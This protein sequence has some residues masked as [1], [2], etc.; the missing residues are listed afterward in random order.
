MRHV[1]NVVRLHL[2]KPEVTFLVPLFILFLVLVISAIISLTLQRVGLDPSNPDFAEGARMNGG[3]TWS[4]PG[5]LVYLGVQAV[6]TTF[7]FALALGS[8][9]RAYVAGTAVANV[10]LA[11]YV[12]VVMMILLAIE[13]A[14]GHWFANIYVLDTFSLGSGNFLQ[15]GLTAFLG[16]FTALSVGGLFGAIWVRFGARGPVVLGIALGLV[17]ALIL[18]LTAPSL[19]TLIP[20]ITG[21][22]VALTVAVL[23][24]AAI[25][26]TW[27]CMR[28]TAVR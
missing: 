7:P 18:F 25:V 11:A 2:N 8:T 4:L 14:T 9:R 27:A 20:Q 23:A 17:L 15:L 1:Q 12:A 24:L 16:T 28:R 22:M 5:F 21:S 10:I 6:A 26:A 13:L 19:A 3:A